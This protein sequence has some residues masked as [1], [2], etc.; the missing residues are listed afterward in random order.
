MVLTV[1][2]VEAGPEVTEVGGLH[3]LQ[4]PEG[5]EEEEEASEEVESLETVVFVRPAPSCCWFLEDFGFGC[6][7]WAPF[8]LIQQEQQV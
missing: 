2:E 1:A 3:C 8:W 4:Q 5:E 7:R 6:W